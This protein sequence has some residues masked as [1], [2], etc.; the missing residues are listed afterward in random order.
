MALGKCL[1]LC[2]LCMFHF[3]KG[4]RELIRGVW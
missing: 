4:V 3:T 2:Y 1:L